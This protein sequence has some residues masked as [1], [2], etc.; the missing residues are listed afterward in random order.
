MFYFI[1]YE[2]NKVKNIE[3]IRIYSSR[4]GHLC[5][6]MD[7]YHNMVAQNNT[8][9][10]KT[11]VFILD[12]TISSNA[13]LDMIKNGL[14]G[15]Y[16]KG[17]LAHILSQLIRVERWNRFVVSFEKIHPNQSRLANTNKWV[18]VPKSEVNRFL[19]KHKLTNQE[20]VVFHNRDEAY[21]NHFNGDGN[22][23]NYRNF[24]FSDY[25]S[26]IST[27][28]KY[29][30]AAI[31]IGKIIEEEYSAANLIKLT[32]ENQ[33]Y[34]TDVTAVEV[35]K[36]FVSGSSGVS[37]LSTLLRKPHLYINL[38]PFDLHHLGSCAQNSLF[39]PKKLRN[40]STGNFLSLKE[41]IDLFRDW[42]IHDRHFFA[43]RKIEV[44]N[45]SQEEINQA[46]IEMFERTNSNWK[47]TLYQSEI[48]SRL[49]KVYSDDFSKYV[50]NDLG[51]QL[52]EF[53]VKQ[54]YK[55][56]FKS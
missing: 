37:H 9:N 19:V 17:K 45:N 10:S 22:F 5:W 46:L 54:N 48:R 51:I 34:W 44:V 15:I 33:D 24:P 20:S 39:I 55:W 28:K 7:N 11:R 38:V 29:N 40:L 4:I 1:I 56:L 6:N 8:V 21:L 41:S 42:T 14:P 52:S 23:H 49:E 13:V 53:F 43:S 31:R 27:L 36:F 16:T 2:I 26:A 18:N 3:I 47:E 50:F 32:G 35:S 30:I 25:A 12:K